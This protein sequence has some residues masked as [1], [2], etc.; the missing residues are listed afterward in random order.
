MCIHVPVHCIQ[1]ARIKIV[2]L[3]YQNNIS[4]WL[5]FFSPP[6]LELHPICTEL[7]MLLV[8]DSEPSLRPGSWISFST[9]ATCQ[10]VVSSFQRLIFHLSVFIGVWFWF[11]CFGCFFFPSSHS[12]SPS[13]SKYLTVNIWC[14]KQ[15]SVCKATGA[16]GLQHILAEGD[17]CKTDLR[18]SVYE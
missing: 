4:S 14:C 9:L 11:C 17:S 13:L 15:L 3:L 2:L 5:L 6:R 1:F 10:H 16:S 12:P 18:Y 8:W 7:F